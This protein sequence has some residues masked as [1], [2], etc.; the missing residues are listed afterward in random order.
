MQNLARFLTPVIFEALWFQNRA[1]NPK[2][3]SR[4]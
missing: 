4:A 2:H 3:A 1:T